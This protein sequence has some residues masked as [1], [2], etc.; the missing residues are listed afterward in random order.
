VGREVVASE[1][2]SLY[3][4]TLVPRRRVSYGRVDPVAAREVFIREALVPGALATKGVFLGHNRGLVAY[5]AQLEHKARRQDV[6]VDEEA[7]AAFYAE[8][9]PAE[10][11][12]GLLKITV[13]QPLAVSLVKVAVASLVPVLDHSVPTWVPPSPRPL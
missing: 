5:I 3:G 12:T 6:L 11:C 4:L 2:V 9:V 7:I 1:R 13:C 10:I 8:R